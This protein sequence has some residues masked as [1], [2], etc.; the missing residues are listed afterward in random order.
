MNACYSYYYE[1][2]GSNLQLFYGIKILLY[3]LWKEFGQFCESLFASFLC[4]CKVYEWSI[5][6]FYH[7][8]TKTSYRWLQRKKIRFLSDQEVPGRHKN[9]Y[10]ELRRFFTRSEIFGNICCFFCSTNG[11]DLIYHHAWHSTHQFLRQKTLHN[12]LEK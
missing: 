7:G 5:K 3:I 10:R 11:K 6:K 2:A 4:F 9:I 8:Y 12:Y 1:C